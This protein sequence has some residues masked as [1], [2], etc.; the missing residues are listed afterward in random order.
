MPSFAFFFN[1]TTFDTKRR[2][3]RAG[4]TLRIDHVGFDNKRPC[5]G[6]QAG[7][8]LFIVGLQDH[9]IHLAGRL[10]IAGSPRP[11]ADVAANTG[12][13][14]LINKPLICLAEP[15]QIDVFR[16]NLLVPEEIATTLELFTVGG[17]STDISSLR[18]GRP[19]PNLFRSCPRL[20][21]DSA[22]QL[23]KLLDLPLQ[24]S[25]PGSAAEDLPPAGID[26]EEYRQQSIKSRRGQRRFR[27]ALLRAY[28]S[29]C[30]VTGCRVEALLEAAHITP[31]AEHT[32]Y[33]VSNGLLLRA[34]IHTLFDLNL[35][36]IDEFY[37]VKMSER[38]RYS[39]YWTYNGRKL[40]RFP[41]RT[42]DQPSTAALAARATLLVGDTD[43]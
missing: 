40:D 8:E 26:D 2:L 36:V 17:E 24:P 15:A 23:R 5:N 43:V 30:V 20:S 6:F 21:A 14:E 1:A 9:R 18:A 28:G 33:R 10:V 7:D 34:D 39:E 37:R 11:R 41:D 16:A 27:E 35:L 38:L 4:Q 29:R 31:H 19:D 3:I 32:D 13:M 22:D 25:A 12:G 42:A